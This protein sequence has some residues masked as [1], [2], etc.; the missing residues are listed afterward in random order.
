MDTWSLL[1]EGQTP[2]P[3]TPGQLIY[4]QGTEAEQFYYIQ[5]GTVKCFISSESGDERTL[6]LHHTGELI[7]EAAFFDGQ[8]RVSS[9]MAVTRCELVS[10][11]RGRL[12]SIFARHPELALPMLEY[13]ARTVRLLSAHVDG[14]FLQA[15]QRVAR[16][17]LTLP[18]AGVGGPLLCTHEE[19]GSAVGV[20]RVTVSRV[21]GEFQRRGWIGTGYRCIQIK[22]RRALEGLLGGE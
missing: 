6:T 18:A 21:L 4:L 19:I 22:N 12:N 7:G 5:K 14:T 15:D 1:A 11:D 9:A 20:S 3:Y 2:Q 10:V 13:L 17:L 16:Y 8:P